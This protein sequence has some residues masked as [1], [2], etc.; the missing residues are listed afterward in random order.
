MVPVLSGASAPRAPGRWIF[1]D[2]NRC[3][4]LV[5]HAFEDFI[6]TGVSIRFSQCIH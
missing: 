3:A 2:I 4:E 6:E 1:D 5:L